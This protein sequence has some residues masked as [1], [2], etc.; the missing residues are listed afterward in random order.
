MVTGIVGIVIVIVIIRITRH[1]DCVGSVI[2]DGD[3][4]MAQ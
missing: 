1:I 4:S 3:G 2:G